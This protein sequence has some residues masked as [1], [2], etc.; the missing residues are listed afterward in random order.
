MNN[1][2]ISLIINIY[3]I[4]CGLLHASLI[5]LF[6]FEQVEYNQ[7]GF[8]FIQLLLVQIAVTVVFVVIKSILE[9]NLK[10]KSGNRVYVKNTSYYL[11]SIISAIGIVALTLL[12][13]KSADF[14]GYTAL[15]TDVIINVIVCR[16]RINNMD[17]ESFYR[18]LY[19][20]NKKKNKNVRNQE[21][22]SF[23]IG[24]LVGL[25]SILPLIIS[26]IVTWV[27]GLE[28]LQNFWI[29]LIAGVV[30]VFIF[31][32]IVEEVSYRCISSPKAKNK[33]KTKKFWLLENILQN[34]YL[35]SSSIAYFLTLAF[36]L[37]INIY[38]SVGIAYFIVY[39]VGRVKLVYSYEPGDG[40]GLKIPD[41]SKKEDITVEKNIFGDNIYKKDGKVV[42]TGKFNVF[43]DEEITDNN[44]NTVAV[45]KKNI[46]G[47]TNYTNN[48]YSNLGQ[49][50]KGFFND[51]IVDSSGKTTYTEE[52]D[53]WG[54]STLHK[55]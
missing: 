16:N 12:F 13:L 15:I 35:A 38:F 4:I 48:D 51:E 36:L 19:D 18:D 34:A 30:P 54:N 21:I 11:Y 55:K 29:I 41:Y 49:K 33:I 9:L 8:Y 22:K 10:L 45:G 25:L 1:K 23:V 7:Q 53:I 42:A 50:K 43:G 2:K 17:A 6:P 44:Y 32:R 47:D 28:L 39:L 46:F 31:P 40:S 24:I 26:I 20:E 14:I 52:K 3:S 37:K 5:M 27:K